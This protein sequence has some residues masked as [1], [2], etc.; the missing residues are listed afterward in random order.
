MTTGRMRDLHSLYRATNYLFTDGTDEFAVRIGQP[1][2]ALDLVL[3]RHGAA[4]AVFI[5]AWNPGSEPHSQ[6]EN[7]VAAAR[8]RAMVDALG[9]TTLPHRGVPD[10]ANWSPEDGLLVLDLGRNGAVTVAE[11]FGQ[12]AIVHIVRG[13]AAEL[14]FTRLMPK[15]G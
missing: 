3:G 10:D 15:A 2:P 8:L 13:G 9:M 6:A 7:E 12:N 14:I 11:A 5:T 4:G 1:S